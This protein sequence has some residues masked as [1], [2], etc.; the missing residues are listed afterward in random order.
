MF[1]RLP[2]QETPESVTAQPAVT[3]AVPTPPVA[4]TVVAAPELLT[5]TETSPAA[6]VPDAVVTAA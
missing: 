1:P 3:V 2:V 6:D 4:D 5:A